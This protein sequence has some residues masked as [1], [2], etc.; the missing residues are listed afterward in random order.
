VTDLSASLATAQ[1]ELTARRQHLDAIR[2]S[3]AD[4]RLRV[5]A[6]ESLAGADPATPLATPDH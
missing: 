1:A 2:A 4:M 3:V 6:L 5:G